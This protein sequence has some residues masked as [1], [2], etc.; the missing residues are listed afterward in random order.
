MVRG[1]ILKID[2]GLIGMEIGYVV[3][4]AAKW[5]LEPER[6]ASGYNSCYH[7]KLPERRGGDSFNLARCT[8]TVA[9]EV[10]A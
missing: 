4:D 6:G 5:D 9:S 1:L 10:D 2:L 3:K 7:R 8:L